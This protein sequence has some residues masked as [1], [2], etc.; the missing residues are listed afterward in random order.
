MCTNETSEKWMDLAASPSVHDLVIPTGIDINN[1]F[2]IAYNASIQNINYIYKYNTDTD[3]WNRIDGCNN[4][5]LQ[6][7]SEFKWFSAALDVKKHLLFLSER[8]Y[9]VQIQ[10]NNGNMNDY[11]TN[12]DTNYPSTNSTS[13]ILNDSLF[14]IGGSEN[15]SIL[16]WDSES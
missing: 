15:N 7:M 8:D 16:K 1:Y 12:I 6:N 11:T 5:Q 4:I 9:V 2:I 3:K 14:I 13:I 10:L